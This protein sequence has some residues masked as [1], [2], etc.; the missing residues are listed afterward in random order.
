MIH[1]TIINIKDYRGSRSE[2]EPISPRYIELYDMVITILLD[3]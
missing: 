2:M 1:Y 3:V